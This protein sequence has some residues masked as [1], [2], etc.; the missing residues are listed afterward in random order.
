M[1]PIVDYFKFLISPTGI[2]LWIAGC[3]MCFGFGYKV[4][5]GIS[6]IIIY[7]GVIIFHLIDSFQSELIFSCLKD[8]LREG[9]ET[10]KKDNE[11]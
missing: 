8:V 7:T 11:R 6:G 1:K 2:L 10:G 9:Y 3:L 4:G 5:L